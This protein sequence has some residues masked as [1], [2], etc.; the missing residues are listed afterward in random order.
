MRS[1]ASADDHDRWGPSGAAPGV[2]PYREGL[3]ISTKVGVTRPSPSE[4]VPLGRPEYLKQQAELSLRRL[5]VERLDLLSG[6]VQ[7]EAE[8]RSSYAPYSRGPTTQG[9]PPLPAGLRGE[10]CRG[11]AS[12][13]GE[14][15]RSPH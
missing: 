4:W 13:A 15:S 3:V 8:V 9:A 2:R 7:R 11:R 1:F 12:Q 14:R 10:K 5:G 6:A